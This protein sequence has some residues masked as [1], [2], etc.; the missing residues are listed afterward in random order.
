MRII[1]NKFS[2]FSE[3][4]IKTLNIIELLIKLQ[5]IFIKFIKE[6]VKILKIEY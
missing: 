3:L 4:T 2:Q 1:T 6:R 5:I